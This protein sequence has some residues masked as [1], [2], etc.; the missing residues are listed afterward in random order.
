[1]ARPSIKQQR[2]EQILE[3]YEICIARYGVEGATLNKVAEQ[4]GIARAL[5]RH[6]VGN[7]DDLL[8]AATERFM[9]RSRSSVDAWLASLPHDNTRI[10]QMLQTLFSD[11]I[12][13]QNDVLVAEAL[14]AAAQARPALKKVVQNW[15]SHFETIITN[16]IRLAYS[17]RD[18][19]DICNVAVGIIGIYFNVASL[20]PLEMPH[21]QQRSYLAAKRLLAT[22]E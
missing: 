5:L 17:N 7:S 13:S 15:W 6:N 10:E 1:M 11:K 8:Q 18:E 12:S 19:Q 4:A 16:E 3:A 14:I 2:T 20:V 22:L 21:I 9:T